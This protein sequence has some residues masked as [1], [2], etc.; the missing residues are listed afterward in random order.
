M[1]LIFALS[2]I[3]LAW[4]TEPANAAQSQRDFTE[5]SLEQLMNVRVTSVSKKP[6]RVSES[7]AAVHVI[8][9]DDIR[10]S[11]ATSVPELL[12]NVPGLHVARI[13]S[14]KWAISTRGFNGRFSNKL[15]VLMDGRSL[16]TPIFSGVFWDVQD[17]FL[18][19]IERIEIIR[20][21]GGTVWGANAVNGVINI[22]TKDSKKTKGTLVTGIMG[23]EEHGNFAA[24]YGQEIDQNSSFRVF[25]KHTKRDAGILPDGQNG[26]DDWDMQR[27]GFR[28]DSTMS[29]GT[30]LMIQGQVYTGNAG[31]LVGFPT[32]TAPFTNTFADDASLNGQFVLGRW[33]S[34]SST[35]SKLNIQ[36]Y[37]DRTVRREA[38]ANVETNTFDIEAQKRQQF[39]TI[40]DVVSGIG[41]RWNRDTVEASEVVAINPS[42]DTY[43]L[44]NAFIQDE[45]SLTD[46]LKLIVGSKIEYNSFSGVEIQPS[47]RALWHVSNSNTLWTAASRAVRTPSR[48]GVGVSLNRAVTPGAP[49]IQ[50]RILGDKDVESEELI[51]LEIGLK[52]RLSRAF[53]LDIA[54]FYNIYDKLVTTEPG[55]AFAETVPGPLHLVLPLTFANNM[56]GDAYGIE[57]G[58]DWRANDRLRLRGAYTYFELELHRTPGAGTASNEAAEDRDPRHQLSVSAQIAFSHNIEID[59]TLRAVDNLSER[60][61]GAYA[62]ADIRVGWRPVENIELSLVGQNLGQNRH[63]EFVPEFLTT[64]ET[65]VERAI[66]GSIKIKF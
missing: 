20:G 5:L 28:Y 27:G 19:D 39:S 1:Y 52:S 8:T 24:R 41:Y 63:L 60:D 40:H 65:E 34:N 23:S 61:V 66:Y 15:L 43:H 18:D 12:R 10:R 29:S 7:A 32:L 62:T 6:Q 2:G 45:I 16:Y 46:D 47:A 44:I 59:T 17:T 42:H 57:I 49:P 56:S 50:P 21:P 25:A 55:T 14:S 53:N 64:K 13:D 9:S 58:A 31:Q 22:I 26:S 33:S 3:V 37:V 48:A 54:T 51:A 30:N 36:M 38:H 35:R 4:W 11:G